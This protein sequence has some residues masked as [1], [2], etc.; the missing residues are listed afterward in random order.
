MKNLGSPPSVKVVGER[1]CAH[2]SQSVELAYIFELYR[3]IVHL[4]LE[5]S[6]CFNYGIF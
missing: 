3:N 1:A 2:L 6:E 4:T 5:I